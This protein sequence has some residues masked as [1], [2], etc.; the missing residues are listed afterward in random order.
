MNKMQKILKSKKGFTLME[1][2]VVLIILAVLVAALIPS[3]VRFAQ[4]ARANT[5]IAEARVGMT[6]AQA[7]VTEIIASGFTLEADPNIQIQTFATVGDVSRFTNYITGDVAAP[8]GFSGITVAGNRVTGLVYTS[9]EFIVTIQ[10]GT[11]TA[12]PNPN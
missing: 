1:I 10:G 5:A 7:V 3:F 4:N 6:A 12:V 9:D 8:E 11:T 2:I